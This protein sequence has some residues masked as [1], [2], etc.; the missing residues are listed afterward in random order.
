M[1]EFR[2]G[3][4]I[5]LLGGS[6]AIVENKLGQGGQGIVYSVKIDGI[7]VQEKIRMMKEA[8]FDRIQER[9]SNK[10]SRRLQRD[11]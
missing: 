6:S 2:K 5:N 8:D 10:S 3:D 7:S 11:H 4:Q 9:R 1:T